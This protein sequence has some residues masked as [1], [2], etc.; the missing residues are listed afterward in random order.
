M[1]IPLHVVAEPRAPAT[2]SRGRRGA[3]AKPRDAAVPT[4]PDSRQQWTQIGL[5]I[6]VFLS[7]ALILGGLTPPMPIP[8]ILGVALLPA[9]LIF[10]GLWRN[11]PESVEA[12]FLRFAVLMAICALAVSGW[13][14]DFNLGTGA[15]GIQRGTDAVAAICV[16]AVV[17]IYALFVIVKR[18]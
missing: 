10:W 16:V 11:R 4:R 17:A 7:S 13:R 9:T 2:E 8:M 18:R 5:A 6:V 3:E 1:A 15:G 12:R 14:L